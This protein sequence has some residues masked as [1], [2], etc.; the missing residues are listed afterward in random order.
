MGEGKSNEKAERSSETFRVNL[1]VH[2]DGT[3][4]VIGDNLRGLVLETENLEEM[5]KE[6]L[7]LTPILLRANH[8]LSDNEV[9]KVLIDISTYRM[10]NGEPKPL[11]KLPKRDLRQMWQNSPPIRAVT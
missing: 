2:E 3:F 1:F 4:T 8:Q 5:Q 11:W 6:L 7:R 10:V 9:D